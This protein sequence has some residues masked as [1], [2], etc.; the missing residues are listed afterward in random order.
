M[1]KI[2][3]SR[4]KIY[5]TKATFVDEPTQHVESEGERLIKKMVQK[6]LD[7]SLNLEE[8]LNQTKEFQ[9][10]TEIVPLSSY[11]KGQVSLKDFQ[12]SAKKASHIEELKSFGLSVDEIE[13]LLDYEKGE[14]EFSEKYKKQETSVLSSR[15]LSIHAKI[16]EGRKRWE[17]LP[18]KSSVSSI[19]RH[20]QELGLC[21]KPDSDYTK[22]LKFALSCQSN[23]AD[24]RPSSHPINNLKHIAE[25]LFGHLAKKKR[26]LR[27]ETGSSCFVKQTVP[28]MSSLQSEPVSYVYKHDAKSLWDVK[29]KET[30]MVAPTKQP[31]IV[32]TYT[33]KPETLYTVKDKKIVPLDKIS[34]VKSSE[35]K[36]NY[37]G[38]TYV[39][40]NI[41]L[42]L[43]SSQMSVDKRNRL[44][45]E[46]IKSLARFK[47]Y[48]EGTPSKVLYLK[49]LAGSVKE[50]DL[51]SLFGEFEDPTKPRI[52]YRLM[53]GKMRGQAFITFP[54]VDAA[55]AAL[56]S[57]NGVLL[58]EK[59]III[60]YGKGAS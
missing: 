1:A 46:E 5:E 23:P 10:S 19:S 36:P 14:A 29:Q 4:A 58:K 49:N 30:E 17:S 27:K 55:K 42:S 54:T 41:D 44:S 53:C 22:L 32:R 8:Q 56:E 16:E 12:D 9:S 48:E 34:V 26:R 45:R 51:V 18:S 6:Q 60:Q 11:T 33:C 37:S 13:I 39:V 50:E 25:E 3:S 21:V 2:E 28:E 43:T 35:A 24:E 57:I 47:D 20:E 40:S 38:Q 15:L 31:E 52:V 7:T 59:P